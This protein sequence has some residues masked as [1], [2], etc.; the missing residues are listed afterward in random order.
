MRTFVVGDIHGYASKLRKLLPLLKARAE[1]GDA[2]VFVGDYIDRGP[3]SRGVIDIVLE[4]MTGGWD[5]P[6]TAL[7]GN[8]EE[9]MLDSL[10]KRPKYGND[11]WMQNGG[12]DTIVSYTTGPVNKQWLSA[13]PPS[14]LEFLRGLGRWHEDENGIYVHAGLPPGVEPEDADDDDRLWIRAP[15]I[16]SDYAW[17]K[18]VVFGHTPQYDE[19]TTMIIDMEKLPWRPLDRPEKIGIDTGVAYGGL[20]SAVILPE[21]EF[22]S[23][24]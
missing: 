24:K 23:V 8:H 11:V 19:P 3:D 4:L 17:D 22:V 7:M 2:L 16:E 9:I 10:Q 6:V 20:L 13:V 18:V 12:Y 14:H 15:F 5:G 21:R 1:S